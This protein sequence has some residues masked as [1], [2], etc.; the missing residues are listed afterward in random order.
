MLL[1]FFSV[2]LITFLLL[3]P[4]I[5]RTTRIIEKP[6]IAIGVDVSQSVVSSSDSAAVRTNLGNDIEH[7][8]RELSDRF[9][10]SIYSF[11]KDVVPGLTKD[12]KGRCTNISSFFSELENRYVNRNLGGVIIATDGLY[13]KGT[14]PYYAAQK[15]TVPVYCITLGDTAIHRDLM[16]K[17]ISVN[18]QVYLNDEFPFEILTGIDK[19][20]GMEASLVI[21]HSG[22]VVFSK[23]LKAAGDHSV[24]R[25]SGILQASEKGMQKYSV[26]IERKGDEFNTVN[27]KR[28][29]YVEVLESR[30]R[31]ALVY[32]SPHPDIAA[33]ASALGS[34]EKFEVFRLKPGDL[35]NRIKEY[36]LYILYQIPSGTAMFDPAKVLPEG[37][38][39]LY[40][41]G[42]KTDLSGFNR[43]NTG[44][45]INSSR[46]TMN[47]IQPIIN[48][49]FTLFTMDRESAGIMSEF[50][51]LQCPSGAFVT[52]AVKD[53]LCYQKIGNVN[54]TFPLILFFDLPGRKTGIIAGENI[55]RW[56]IS[57]YLQK[58]DFR[59]FDDMISRIVQYLSVKS[60]PSPFRVNV[61]TSIGEGDPL[62]FDAALF[63]A[64]HEL[65]NNPEVLLEL[66]NEEGKSYPYSFTRTE[67]TYYL[68][69]GYFPAGNYTYEASVKTARERYTRQGRISIIPLDVELV[70]L[71]ADHSLLSHLSTAYDAKVVSREN[72]LQ[73]SKLL[74]ERADFKSVIHLQRKYTD[75]IAEWWMFLL[76]VILLSSEWALRKRNGM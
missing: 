39:V 28:D 22:K 44:L 67:K 41:I 64:S 53:V 55:W 74:K 73:L 16:I 9:D 72:M 75:L 29:F 23:T 37:S 42:S 76:V 11:S 62:E 56:R 52:A 4:L 49:D 70:N 61:K 32:E 3:T 59:F 68:N 25:V 31:V 66:K 26:E 6:I 8:S 69:A 34:S 2:S 36:D 20:M 48:R 65:I 30:I 71:V 18:K 57:D 17:Q 50:P 51:P 54:T 21:R 12:F 46:N 19:Y 38:P 58:S 24:V 33:I 60:D 45:I 63:N 27:N 5:R 1:R 13:N 7:L 35:Q 43:L 14:N 15:L 47:D 10:V 40:I